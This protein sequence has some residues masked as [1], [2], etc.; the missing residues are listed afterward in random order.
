MEI[1]GT[2]MTKCG[3]ERKVKSASTS[4]LKPCSSGTSL[5][6]LLPW[7]RVASG[8]R[9][10]AL[11]A[12]KPLL[13]SAGRRA[14]SSN[15]TAEPIA[16]GFMVQI[17]RVV[18]MKAQQQRLDVKIWLSPGLLRVKPDRATLNFFFFF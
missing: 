12:T 8:V 4:N 18:E 9:G 3:E 2:Y 6:L 11:G 17:I 10:S 14:P 7:T 16:F 5:L 1:C 15:F 13:G